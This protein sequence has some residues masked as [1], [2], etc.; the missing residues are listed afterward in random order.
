MIYSRMI[1][2]REELKPRTNGNYGSYGN[3]VEPLAP[4]G[5]AAVL[6]FVRCSLGENCCFLG[7]CW[8]VV[9]CCLGKLPI[10]RHRRCH[11]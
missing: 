11:I 6:W 5:E 8:I 1:I 3:Y 10:S 2:K 9:W 7:F 4:M